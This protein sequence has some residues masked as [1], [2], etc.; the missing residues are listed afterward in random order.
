MD[1]ARTGSSA[2]AGNILHCWSISPAQLRSRADSIILLPCCI[3]ITEAQ[4]EHLDFLTPRSV[5]PL[6]LHEVSRAR[7]QV[8]CWLWV[9]SPQRLRQIK[10]YQQLPEFN[11]VPTLSSDR[12]ETQW[13]YRGRL[14]RAQKLKPHPRRISK[15]LESIMTG[16]VLRVKKSFLERQAKGCSRKWEQHGKRRHKRFYK[17]L[18]KT[19]SCTRPS[20]RCIVWKKAERVCWL[21][22]KQFNIHEEAENNLYF[23]HLSPLLPLSYKKDSLLP[24]PPLRAYPQNFDIGSVAF[25]W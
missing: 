17:G 11:E 13:G 10:R 25:Y 16:C 24:L 9:T 18:K 5:W 15:Y 4:N 22:P 2:R 1:A 7:S 6:T 19:G 8:L 14:G 12:T 3:W 20:L 21:N 23:C